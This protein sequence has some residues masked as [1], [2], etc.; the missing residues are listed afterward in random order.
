[1][2]DL[3]FDEPKLNEYK[4]KNIPKTLRSDVWDRYIGLDIGRTKCLCCRRKN[5]TQFDFH[6][7]HV[8]AEVKGGNTN[9]DNLRPICSNCNLSMGV[10]NMNDFIREFGYDRVSLRVI[11]SFF[12]CTTVNSIEP[13]YD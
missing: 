10:K 11:K 4:K 5:I 9:V 13:F 2:T 8:V 3:K 7:G 1:M 6:C 12:C